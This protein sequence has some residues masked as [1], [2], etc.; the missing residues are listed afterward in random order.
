MTNETGH[1]NYRKLLYYFDNELWVH[2]KDLD[3]IF[4]NGLILDLNEEKLTLVLAE[5]VRGEIPILLENI[6]TDSIET[7]KLK[8]EGN[9]H[10]HKNL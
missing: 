7:F 1:T 9:E 10:K 4:Y 3:G 5:R 8:E 6:N 2:F